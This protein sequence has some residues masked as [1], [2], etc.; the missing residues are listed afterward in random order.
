MPVFNNILAGA[1]GQGGDTGFK[2][3][4][5]LRFNPDDTSYL[6]KTFSSAGDRKTYTFS[7]W[8]K[9]ASLGAEKNLLYADNTWFRFENTDHIYFWHSQG[10]LY[11][12]AKFK[13]PN[14][15]Y[16]VVL[17]V[18]TRQATASD[19]VK[20]YVNGV[21]Q[22]LSGSG[23]PNQNAEGGHNNAA[24][25]N[26]GRQ[27]TDANLFDGYM[28]EVHFVDGQALAATAFG[29]F[30]AD[31]GVWNPI[32][33]AGDHS[34]PATGSNPTSTSNV[35]P[36]GG[37]GNSIP[38][39]A[40]LFSLA[41]PTSATSHIRQD[42]GG[43]EW[44][45]AI[46]LSG[47]D[48]A[49]AFL[50]YF[51]NASG[52][53]NVEFKI[54]GSWVTAQTNAQNVIGSTQNQGA[55]ITLATTGSWT[56]V[57]VTGGSNVS[58]SGVLG[59]YKNGS[60]LHN[61]SFNGFYLDFSDTSSDAALGYDAA[62]SNNF[63]VNN[64]VASAP[65][66]KTLTRFRF[67]TDWNWLYVSG[68]K[69]NG[70]N[71]TGTLDN[72]G[73]VWSNINA[74]QNGSHG[75][76]NETYSQSARGDWFDVTLTSGIANFSQFEVHLY[77]DSSAGST[78]NVFE[79]ELFFSDGTS[80]TKV[81]PTTAD[82]PNQN[83]Y[84]FN[85]RQWQDFGSVGIS[86]QQDIDS[87]F[88]SPS[89][90]SSGGNDGGNYATLNRLASNK[91]Q[92]KIMSN[93]NLNFTGNTSSGSGY[94]TVFSTL[95]MASGKF[96]CEALIVDT[97]DNSGV[98]VGVCDS[99]MVTNEVAVGSTYP[100]GPGG[101]AYSA[102]GQMEQN[103]SVVSTGNGNYTGGDVIGIAYDA[104][105]GKLYFSK[106]GTFVNSAN[107]ATGANPNISNIV[108][109]QF[110][111]FGVYGNRGVIVNFGQRP[112]SSAIP[113]GYTTLCSQNLGSSLVPK[114]STAFDITLF[115]NSAQSSGSFT[116]SI[117]PDLIIMKRR[118][119]STN[120]HSQDIVRGYGDNK[121][122]HPNLTAAETS[123]GNITGVSGTTV[124]YGTNN[125]MF[126]S[127]VAWYWDAGTTNTTVAAGS[128]NSSVYNQAQVW[129]SGLSANTGS[130]T[131]AVRAFDGDTQYSQRAYT[132]ASSG[133]NDRVIT[134][135]LGITLNN[136]YVDVYPGETYSGYYATIDGTAQPTQYVGAI[137]GWKRMGPFTGTL[138]SVSV[139]NGTD[140]SSRSAAIRAIRVAGKILVDSNRTPDNAP[141]VETVHRTNADAGL[142][143]C[144]YTGNG[145]VNMPSFAHGLG[146]VPSFVIVKNRD[147]GQSYPDWYVKHK[148][149]GQGYN[150]RLN[151][152]SQRELASSWYN[153]GIGDLD[154]PHIVD[155]VQ[156]SN[157][158]T[159]NVNSTNI[160]YIAY[161]WS[162]RPG[163]SAFGKYVGS[164]AF[165]Y[166]GFA[167]RWLMIA[168]YSHGNED[169]LVL[170]MERSQHN[171]VDESVY[172]SLT[173][174]ESGNDSARGV[175]FLSNGFRIRGGNAAVNGS[176][177][178][179]V[180]AAFASNPLK[181]A[182][183]L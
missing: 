141:N 174:A 54:N 179:Y 5:S 140:T 148:D 126:N 159:G 178:E 162:E 36:S 172:F 173:H 49:G 27:H 168:P 165:V 93:G 134:A 46:T 176:N 117:T 169:W 111:V 78:T 3:S 11:T 29:E 6:T 50:T 80:H 56:G 177:Y 139:T 28:A 76:G 158:S 94:P 18:D 40:L 124:S 107:P 25:H 10:N 175:D 144:A 88:D 90:Y 59:I 119:A 13:D 58:V 142:S 154:S 146:T 123:T 33:F 84:G 137:N 160:K 121:S 130:V 136:D 163:Y 26:I 32:E 116:T 151:I 97:T 30:D 128:L 149:V 52:S 31:T 166:T 133:S 9:I 17:S 127:Q 47:S 131:Y 15:W 81:Y 92:S 73:S 109:E 86:M 8:V 114:G 89:S 132:S 157:N 167:V 91:F 62:G 41:G 125:N 99:Q 2:I 51:N 22:P 20:I 74:W 105:S 57:R 69:V 61:G 38:S 171:T 180:W 181:I 79:I 183:A 67:K 152:K 95:G 66:L 4:R 87:L 71:A 68:V 147:A 85:S 60:K 118:D 100:G 102:H 98:Y 34:A 39:A 129:S 155:L 108:G 120:W 72:S 115:N 55:L 138:T 110:F 135:T 75:S 101:N 112:F 64:L 96:Y 12:N 145:T 21:N 23:Y 82:A 150:Q 164:A 104:D 16:H 24:A 7:C 42:G 182:R 63:T 103:S 53:F 19:R 37:H 83:A 44:S 156:G 161:C 70:S 143:I 106:N 48:V 65:A 113:S 45:P 77:L 122:L 153:G 43:M 170:D 14:A 35:A 1:A